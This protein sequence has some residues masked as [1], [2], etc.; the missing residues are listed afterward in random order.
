MDVLH[1]QTAAE[2]HQSKQRTCENCGEYVTKQ[3][4][5]VFGANDGSVYG[6]MNC[7]TGR[8][9]REGAGTQPSK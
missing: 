8:D 1:T 7:L 3:F 2:S 9:L 4:V 6:C 5:R